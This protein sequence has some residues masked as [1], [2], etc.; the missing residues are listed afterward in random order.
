[1]QRNPM[2]GRVDLPFGEDDAPIYAVDA[3][4]T[5]GNLAVRGTDAGVQRNPRPEARDWRRARAQVKER[6]VAAEQ[7]SRKRAVRAREEAEEEERSRP[8]RE[9]AAQHLAAEKAEEEREK[10]RWGKRLKSS[11]GS[12]TAARDSSTSSRVSPITGRRVQSSSRRG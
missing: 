9:R 8:D 7:L 12:S 5:A 3:A 10:Q 6:D 4:G 1:M 2:D 11:G